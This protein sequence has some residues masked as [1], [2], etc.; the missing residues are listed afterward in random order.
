MAWYSIRAI[1]EHGPESDGVR[2]YEE[3]TLLF[4]ADDIE[5]AFALAE[6]ES[7]RYLKFNPTFERVG[8]WVAFAVAA[9]DDGLEGREIWSGL[10]RSPLT[11][12]Q[13]YEH[14]YT[15]YEFQPSEGDEAG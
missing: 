10:S 13:Y 6:S 12:D 14:R 3:R 9:N 4:R 8:E 11:G 7:R 2:L 5:A 1:Y 15:A